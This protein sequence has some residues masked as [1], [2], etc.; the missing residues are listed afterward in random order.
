MGKRM[1]VI[2]AAVMCAA[3]MTSCS[4]GESQLGGDDVSECG[5]SAF[6]SK[7]G[8][9]PL[10]VAMAEVPTEA[11]N[12]YGA[13]ARV[14]IDVTKPD[15]YKVGQKCALYVETVLQNPQLPTGCEITALTELLNYYGFKADKVQMA[16]IFMANDR[17]G[18]YTMN[19]AYIGDP[20]QEDG[21]G[22]N[23][24]VI[25]K[26]ANDYFDYIGSDWYAADLT[27]STMAQ[28]YYQIEQGRPVIVWT[29]IDQVEIGKEYAF[30][31]GCG[32]DLWFN[33]MQHCVV[34][35]GFD[36]D[37][38]VV[39]VADPLVGNR[40]YDMARFEHIYASMDKQAVVLCGH[41][42]SAGVD[43]TTNEQKSEWM[44][45][46]RIFENGERV[47]LRENLDLLIAPEEAEEK[48]A[49]EEPA[50]TNA[51]TTT[52]AKT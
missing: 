27:G 21:F 12:E 33:G 5:S 40:K 11:T 9:E 4:G 3:A 28:I 19:E 26:A 24:P 36:Y 25:V 45:K 47:W 44:K 32:E 8:I 52:E 20:H 41:E 10:T 2:A 29:T 1:C 38:K 22:C 14:E 6:S 51:T 50:T 46:N 42:E 31:L 35:Y 37:E 34:L 39:H 16:D 30:E 7:S 23:A 18:Y 13:P 48:P 17:I 15:D 43:Y 49:R